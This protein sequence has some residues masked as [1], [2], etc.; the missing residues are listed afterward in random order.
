MKRTAF[1]VLEKSLIYPCFRPTASSL[2]QSG[3]H[4]STYSFQKSFQ[5]KTEKLSAS[6]TLCSLGHAVNTM[7]TWDISPSVQQQQIWQMFVGESSRFLLYQDDKD[8]LSQE[9]KNTGQAITAIF[10]Q[11]SYNNK[12]CLKFSVEIMKDL[13]Y[14]AHEACMLSSTST[15]YLFLPSKSPTLMHLPSRSPHKNKTEPILKPQ[16]AQETHTAP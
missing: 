3:S 16:P 1:V 9:K 8:T 4:K 2:I 14:I 7:T 13:R 10:Y 15:F 6:E 11:F 5:I 12:V